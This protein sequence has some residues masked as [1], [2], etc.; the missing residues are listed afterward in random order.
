MQVE[1]GENNAEIMKTNFLGLKTHN[2]YSKLITYTQN[3]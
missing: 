3:S 2:L 1:L